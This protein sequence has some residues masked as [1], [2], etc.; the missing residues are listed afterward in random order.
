MLKRKRQCLN[1]GYIAYMPGNYIHFFTADTQAQQQR[2]QDVWAR[3]QKQIVTAVEA[4]QGNDYDKMSWYQ[5]HINS[6][7]LYRIGAMLFPRWDVLFRVDGQCNACGLCADVCPVENI[8]MKNGKPK[9]RHHCE[10]CL[11]CI[12]LCPQAAIQSSRRT[13]HRKRYRNPHVD[14]KDLMR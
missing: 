5:Q 7:L 3:Q 11:A 8:E 12:N 14:I 10:Q 13:P 4:R 2:K 1:A 9:W 6:G